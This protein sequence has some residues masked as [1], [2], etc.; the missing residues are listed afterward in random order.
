MFMSLLRSKK[1]WIF[2]V[3]FWV[4]VFEPQRLVEVIVI[5]LADLE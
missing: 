2:A 1:V 5:L 3:S 4:P